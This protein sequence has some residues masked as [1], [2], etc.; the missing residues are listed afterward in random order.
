MSGFVSW[1]LRTGLTGRDRNLIPGGWAEFQDYDFHFYANDDS[2]E[3]TVTQQWNNAIMTACQV[4]GAEGSPGPHLE[5][6]VRGAGFQQ[7]HHERFVIPI[8]PW[9]R[10]RRLKELGWL[11]LE[12]MVNGLEGFS[13]RLLGHVLGWDH[14][15]IVETLARVREELVSRRLHIQFDL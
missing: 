5:G 10:N 3:G 4:N 1:V 6:W 14:D 15:Q 11:N 13:F 2:F 9:A 12:Q 8:G 7:I